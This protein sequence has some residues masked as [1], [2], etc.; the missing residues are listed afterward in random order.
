MIQLTRRQQ[1]LLGY[2][3]GMTAC[4]PVSYT[5]LL[6]KIIFAVQVKGRIREDDFGENEDDQDE[7]IELGGMR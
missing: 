3:S 7:K 2:L 6:P 1:A 5:H 4:V